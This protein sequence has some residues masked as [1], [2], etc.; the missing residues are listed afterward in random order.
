MSEANSPPPDLGRPR[1]KRPLARQG[2]PAPT[3][4][5]QARAA[6][7][8]GPLAANLGVIAADRMAY[9]HGLAATVQAPLADGPAAAEAQIERTLAPASKGPA[10]G[11]EPPARRP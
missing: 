6:R 11:G 4:Y 1:A 8:H 7:G 2:R 10:H 5:F 3:P 9:A